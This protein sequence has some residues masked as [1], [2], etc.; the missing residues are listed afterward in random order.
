MLIMMLISIWQVVSNE[1]FDNDGG[2]DM[3]KQNC[4]AK[5]KIIITLPNTCMKSDFCK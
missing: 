2:F 1:Q 5:K 3:M 4:F